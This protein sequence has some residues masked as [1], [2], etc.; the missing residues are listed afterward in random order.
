[1]F[2]QSFSYFKVEWLRNN[3]DTIEFIILL[4]LII[5]TIFRRKISSNHEYRSS[6]KP[7]KLFRNQ[8]TSTT[9]SIKKINFKLAKEKIASSIKRFRNKHLKY[10][11]TAISGNELDDSTDH[12]LMNETNRKNK[13]Q[14]DD[15]SIE[16]L[17]SIVSYLKN[18]DIV[19]LKSISKQMHQNISN[20][21]LWEQLWIQTYGQM[22]LNPKIRKI[23]EDR[24]I[25]WSPFG[26]SYERPQQGWYLFYLMFEVCWVDWILAG[27][28][29]QKRSLIG[30]DN[31]IFDVTKF[32][33]KHPGSLGR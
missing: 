12:K 23:R 6:T 13:F 30:I 25:F 32:I 8:I 27:Y 22:W 1:M 29:T 11:S 9:S 28:C 16:I 17:I 4:I 10:I 15:L 7:D 24:G 33:S 26:I 18:I 31:S 2:Y 14:I 5:L 19:N 21:C 20:E 3:L